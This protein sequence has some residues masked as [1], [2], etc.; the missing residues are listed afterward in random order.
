MEQA[1]R[2]RL[3]D[4]YNAENMERD[5]LTYGLLEAIRYGISYRGRQ[6]VIAGIMMDLMFEMARS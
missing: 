1:V 2:V 5:I 6:R 4:V 3:S